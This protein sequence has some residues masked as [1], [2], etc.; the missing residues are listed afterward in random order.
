METE[1]RKPTLSPALA[2]AAVALALCAPA[3]AAP[4]YQVL[5]SFNG[6]DGSG[7]YGG[8]TFG[9]QGDLYGTTAGGGPCGTVFGLSPQK[10]DQWEEIVLYQ[11]GIDKDG[12]DPW[13][14][15]TFDPAGNLYGTTIGGGGGAY[16]SGTVF[17]LSPGSTGWTEK[18]LFAFDFNDG[19]KPVAGVALDDSGN[20]YGTTPGGGIDSGGTTFELTPTSDGWSKKTL[21][22]FHYAING[23]P[24]PGGS[25]PYAAVILD[26]AGNLYGTTTGGGVDCNDGEGCGTVYELTPTSGGGWKE[27]VLHRFHEH[28]KD[29]FIPG[30]GALLMDSVGNLYGTTV[31]GGCCGGVVFK[32]T[33]NPDG[34]WTETILH[35]FQG[36]AGGDL[37]YAGVVMDTAGNLYGTT[38]GGGQASGCG[39]I[40][41]LAPRAK[42]KWK[43]TVLYSFYGGVDGCVPA[44]NLVLDKKGNLYGGTILGGSSGNGVIFEITP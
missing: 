10:S 16:D 2:L 22:N 31:A 29:G 30:N 28:S 26:A 17:E 25:T 38:D 33:P 41:K 39:V 12:C 27:V 37:P 18:V 34:H 9:P 5:H 32:L 3:Y 4:K 42:G 14:G 6:T 19:A 13:S 15:V 7:P 21:H 20:L 35:A 40:Y 24:A 44:G 36:G 8:V 23:H 11:F 43:Y 1:R